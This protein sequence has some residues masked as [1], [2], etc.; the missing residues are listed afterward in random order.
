M[1]TTL[2]NNRT[3][4][5]E[6]E[7]NVI[8][9]S[10]DRATEP[11]A[12]SRMQEELKQANSPSPENLEEFRRLMLRG[13][14]A[15]MSN[16]NA[17][18]R[19][20]LINLSRDLVL[21]TLDGKTIDNPEYNQTLN[22][23][24]AK[25][26]EV[27]GGRADEFNFLV[28][29]GTQPNLIMNPDGSIVVSSGLMELLGDDPEMYVALLAH[30]I[31][32]F[33]NDDS[34]KRFGRAKE[35]LDFLNIDTSSMKLQDIIPTAMF[36]LLKPENSAYKE[37]LE[38]ILQSEEAQADSQGIELAIKA[39]ISPEIIQQSL[40]RLFLFDGE[41]ERSKVQLFFDSHPSESSRLYSLRRQLT[42]FR[43]VKE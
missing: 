33:D 24:L 7:I 26:N 4:I 27:R 11:E 42:E 19:N 13:E 8:P 34:L 32:H 35:V 18:L 36:E 31:S 37:E 12:R 3:N 20:E 15:I 14:E 23:A 22:Q 25:I 1:N 40:E 30:E 10:A 2:V 17:P 9:L 43:E 38:Q 29:S 16:T 41:I 6:P 21:S 28:Y 5:D 39:G